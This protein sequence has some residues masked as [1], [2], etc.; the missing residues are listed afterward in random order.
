MTQERERDKEA[1]GAWLKVGLYRRS[2]LAKLSKDADWA[3]FKLQMFSAEDDNRGRM[4]PRDVLV[5]LD[6]K[7]SQRI[8]DKLLEELADAGLV[9]HV[10]GMLVLPRFEDE[11]PPAETWH[12]PVKRERWARDKR[13]KRD[14]E[15]CR[16]IK[17][18]DRNLCRFCGVRV[19]WDDRNGDTG[20]TYDHLDP[21]G[22]NSFNNVVVSCRGCNC[23]ATGKRD[24]TV[25]QW[26]AAEP[27]HGRTL[28][29]PGTTAEQAEAIDRSRWEGN[30][31]GP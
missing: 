17:E 27:R 7:V 2:A 25:E 22:D 23:A 9:E 4:R 5:A 10:D 19:N 15:L 30:G 13:L 16:R 21:D 24:R 20:G 3:W 6:R 18:R 12:D 1:N 31:T 14:G 26:I 28:K 29:K 11:N 8:A